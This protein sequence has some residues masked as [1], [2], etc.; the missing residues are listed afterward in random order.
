MSKEAINSKKSK[1]P[2]LNLT[3]SN[4]QVASE[5]NTRKK[6]SIK[7][8]E[9]GKA[10]ADSISPR[11]EATKAERN[12]IKK[13]TQ[14]KLSRR[15]KDSNGPMI[16][17]VR[18]QK[19]QYRSMQSFDPEEVATLRQ[20]V[21][22]EKARTTD[23]MGGQKTRPLPKPPSHGRAHLLAQPSEHMPG[24]LTALPFSTSEEVSAPP[25]SSAKPPAYAPPP[26]PQGKVRRSGSMPA[27]MLNS[28]TD[29]DASERTSLKTGLFLAPIKP[30]S[31]AVEKNRDASANST[32]QSSEPSPRSE[33][34]RSPR[35]PRA[36]G[37]AQMR[38]P[39]EKLPKTPR[40]T[41]RQNSDS[42][43]V[44]VLPS[45]SRGSARTREAAP[46]NPKLNMD[47]FAYIDDLELLLDAYPSTSSDEASI[48]RKQGTS[49]GAKD[50]ILSR[51]R[52]LQ[53]YDVFDMMIVLAGN[54]NLSRHLLP[55][56]DTA[57][58]SALEKLERDV[59]IPPDVQTRFVNAA[60][61][62]AAHETA[63]GTDVDSKAMRTLVVST[64]RCL[65]KKIAVEQKR[66]HD[67]HMKAAQTHLERS[68]EFVDLVKK[69]S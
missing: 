27:I 66:L 60:L 29:T 50:L 4:T 32:S 69:L 68:E 34:P 31:A 8:A 24:L 30:A 26:V 52:E 9:S 14:P 51:R 44:S 17:G 20:E 25:I 63:F 59:S 16:D 56:E 15:E 47:E 46:T 3:Q 67:E 6:P 54:S 45:V 35:S 19:R 65:A 5:E 7:Q 18:P 62:V 49:H 40:G 33:E 55:I 10:E 61:K 36:P 28:L 22:T 42:Q 13:S 53:N 1:V 39:T 41:D 64:G 11:K 58:I 38:I 21:K 2:K 43:P 12:P 48:S 23:D 37:V 57:L